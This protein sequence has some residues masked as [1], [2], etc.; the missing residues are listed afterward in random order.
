MTAHEPA[1]QRRGD[2]RLPR[3]E[4]RRAAVSDSPLAA[5]VPPIVQDVLRASGRPLDDATREF[6]E[7][8]FGHDF[9]GV[10]VHTDGQGAA[11]AR[12]EHARAYTVGQDIAFGTGHYAPGTGAGRELLAHEL[13]HVVQ[14]S[15]Y[16]SGGDGSTAGALGTVDA[17][18]Q[19]ARRIAPRATSGTGR[20]QVSGRGGLRVSRQEDPP[21]SRPRSHGLTPAEGDLLN[22]V[23][24]RLVPADKRS[25]A[26]VGV[27]IAEDGRRFE[28]VSGGG[29][30][31][32]SHV[33]G[34]ATAKMQEEG[35]TRGTLLVEKSPCQIC[36]RST[37]SQPEGPQQPM[38]SSR[39]GEP[40]DRQTPKIN[41]ALTV[42][43]QLTVV[44]PDDASLYRGVKPAPRGPSVRPARRPPAPKKPTAPPVAKP[45][46]SP[47]PSTAATAAPAPPV[48]AP[49][50]GAPKGIIGGRSA[51]VR[52]SLGGGGL[53]SAGGAAAGAVAAATLNLVAQHYLQREMDQKNEVAFQQ[54]MR[55]QQED[56]AAMVAG[57]D[58]VAQKLQAQGRPVFVNVTVY[59]RYQT[60]TSGQLG[61][62]T[63][64]MDVKVR[65]VEVTSTK[66]EHVREGKLDEGFA[67]YALKG[68][69][70]MSE[71][72]FYFSLSYP[73]LEPVSGPDPGAMPPPNCFIATACYGSALAPEV[74]LL[75]QFRDEWLRRHRA[76]RL[77]VRAYYVLSPP[78][79]GYLRRHGT[80]RRVV[81]EAVV[82][83]VVE[84]VEAAQTRW[85]PAASGQRPVDP[86][87][88]GVLR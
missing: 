68:T 15:G 49:V 20:L 50:G 38:R 81:R 83:P 82:A 60:D 76:G 54:K 66:L 18:E 24:G 17:L 64:L 10:R 29:Q 41:T 61:G 52:P 32:S 87:E 86:C 72:L 59:V 69:F 2:D 53:R 74:T 40:I 37:Y 57:Q 71:S 70:G 19:E 62:V 88:S 75:R 5:E 73:D 14:Q 16:P 47:A 7:Q 27:L 25:T 26:I 28:L 58:A 36:D 9:S 48:Q 85:R 43:S 46:K 80:A 11:A 34:K 3:A 1:R 67:T 42:G 63:A 84:L 8:R 21:S 4:F 78:V 12:A 30:G 56:I 65:E 33:E 31:F 77:F 23:R 22:E 45:P 13:I 39:T 51:G 55:A 44:D 6:M 35:I 79:A